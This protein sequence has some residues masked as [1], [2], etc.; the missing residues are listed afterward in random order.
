LRFAV[1]ERRPRLL[2]FLQR[3]FQLE[4]ELLPLEAA[5]IAR[6][7]AVLAELIKRAD[8]SFCETGANVA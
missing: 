2:G 7:L 6:Q 1:E 4:Q 8:R 5:R 3:A